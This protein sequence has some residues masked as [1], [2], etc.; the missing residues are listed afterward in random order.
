M[1]L[2]SI[3]HIQFLPFQSSYPKRSDPGQSSTMAIADPAARPQGM[4]FKIAITVFGLL[5]N[6]SEF[7]FLADLF[8]RQTFSQAALH[9]DETACES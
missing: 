2:I 3:F 1:H 5:L 6:K 9:M 4:V 8:S 7:E